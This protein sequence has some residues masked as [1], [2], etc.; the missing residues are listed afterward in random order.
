MT[1][2]RVRHAPPYEETGVSI[3]MTD[4]Y[5]TVD[6]AER[7]TL[8]EWKKKNPHNITYIF[9]GDEFMGFI[10]ILP[11]TMECGALFDRQ[12]MLEEDLTA[13]FILQPES[14]KYAQYLYISG[15]AVPDTSSYKSKTAAA[16]LVSCGAGMI[17]NL[18]GG[19][20][21]KRVYANPTTYWG[22]RIIGRFGLKPM[23]SFKKLLRAGNDPYVVEAD[24][25]FWDQMAHVEKRY[26]RFLTDYPWPLE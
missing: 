26:Q 17:R 4:R 1:R 25:K 9:D 16:A 19:G 14:M 6:V 10:E 18:Y 24:E 22:N 2:F 5:F 3:P 7:K 23:S 20:H 21:L 8:E 13:E 11:L 15:I 12:E